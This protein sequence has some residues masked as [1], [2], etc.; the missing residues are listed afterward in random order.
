M[1]SHFWFK[2]TESIE[3][4]LCLY[5]AGNQQILSSQIEHKKK[6]VNFQPMKFGNTTNQFL[7][8]VHV[9]VHVN[10]V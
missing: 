7:E 8:C 1:G 2:S 9:H 10:N 5:R 6:S 4:K 3:V